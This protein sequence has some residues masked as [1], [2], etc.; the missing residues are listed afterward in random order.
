MGRALSFPLAF[1]VGY[2]ATCDAGTRIRYQD[3]SLKFCVCTGE[4]SVLVGSEVGDEFLCAVTAAAN[5]YSLVTSESE[6][7][8]IWIQHAN[9]AIQAEWMARVRTLGGGT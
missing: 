4:F 1:I 9:K 3:G 8:G 2:G 6:R 7:G 5:G